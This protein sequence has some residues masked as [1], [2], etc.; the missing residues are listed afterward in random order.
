MLFS[1]IWPDLSFMLIY[2]A[3]AI[4]KFHMAEKKLV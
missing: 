4:K 2:G 1:V 3:Y